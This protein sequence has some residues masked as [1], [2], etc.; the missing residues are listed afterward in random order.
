MKN[1]K[2]LEMLQN[3]QID[4]LK[5]I[6]QDEIFQ[7]NLGGADAKK[8]YKA[9]KSYLSNLD[10]DSKIQDKFSKPYKV[11]FDDIKYTCFLDGYCVALTTEST[12]DIELYNNGTSYSDDIYFKVNNMIDF[13]QYKSCEKI[14]INKVLADAKSKGYKMNKKEISTKFTTVGHYKDM[15][16][17]IGLLDRA[18]SI[19]ANNGESEVYYLNKK[20]PLLIKNSL[21][22]ALVLP[23][24]YTDEILKNKIVIEM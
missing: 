9:M 8:R 20:F 4:E 12:G 6:I 17:K 24:N 1:E 11:N 5:T 3:N 7:S 15:I 23:I 13:S 10:K 2:I 16:F 22:I 18:Y 21:G 14:N 19:I